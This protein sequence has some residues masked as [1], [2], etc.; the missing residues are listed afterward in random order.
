[1]TLA[2]VGSA[3]AATD[4]GTTSVGT[5]SNTITVQNAKEG[6]EYKLYKMLDLATHTNTETTA[7]DG[8]TYTINNDWASFF[9]SS[10]AGAS[11]VTVSNNIN[12]VQYV[13]WNGDNDTDTYAAFGTAAKNYAE[14]NSKVPAGTV[15]A[16]SA[17]SA[18]FT[19]VANGYY[20]VISSLGNAASVASTPANPSQT[21]QEKNEGITDDK[22]VLEAAERNGNAAS[23]GTENDAAVGDVITFRATVKLVK[24]ST[25]VTYH[26]EMGN[27]LTFLSTGDYAVITAKGSDVLVRIRKFKLY[28]VIADPK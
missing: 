19:N 21:I 23:Y 10:G 14:T 17:N 3:M 4:V 11:Y 25:K 20:L 27:E 28:T 2:L 22:E 9:T 18:S 7:L 8:F 24:D 26:D 6:Q 13:T 15:I 16:N 5:G 12:G 1:M